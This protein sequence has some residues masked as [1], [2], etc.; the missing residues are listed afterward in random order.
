[1]QQLG[2]GLLGNKTEE[3]CDSSGEETAEKLKILK[4]LYLKNSD[5]IRPQDACFFYQVVYS[6]YFNVKAIPLFFRL[7]SNAF[8][9]IGSVGRI[10]RKKS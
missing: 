5:Q 8:P 6:R 4:Q 2:N 1:M 3:T 10:E 7:A 9:G